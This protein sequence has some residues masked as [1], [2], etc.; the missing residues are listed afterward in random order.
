MKWLLLKSQRNRDSH[1]VRFPLGS[2]VCLSGSTVLNGSRIVLVKYNST[3]CFNDI[4]FD[5]GM[6]SSRLTHKRSWRYW[7]EVLRCRVDLCPQPGEAVRGVSTRRWLLCT[8]WE[9]R[10]ETS[11]F[12]RAG[13]SPVTG[14]HLKLQ[15]TRARLTM[16]YLA[17]RRV[18]IKCCL[19]ST[20]ESRLRADSC[21]CE[22]VHDCWFE[23]VISS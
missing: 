13:L 7:C 10:A 20:Q 1:I 15:C 16:K 2:R 17:P 8:G 11:G 6:R 4:I 3:I 23:W 21:R 22:N 14:D 5:R 18:R 12:D 19:F 9:K